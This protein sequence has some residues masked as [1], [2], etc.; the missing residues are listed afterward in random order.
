VFH[1]ADVVLKLRPVVAKL[2]EKWVLQIPGTPDPSEAW[3]NS[4]NYQ[5]GLFKEG[6]SIKVVVWV[7]SDM[8]ETEID[9][10]KDLAALGEWII[11]Q[12]EAQ[13][14]AAMRITEEEKRLAQ[15]PAPSLETALA[16]L[17]GGTRMQLGWGRWYETYFMT[18]G[19]LYRE[20][21]DEGHYDEVEATPEELVESMNNNREQARKQ[22]EKH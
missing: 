8:Q 2:D 10:L 11:P 22:C 12:L 21:F 16:A 6:S 14:V 15:I 9:S 3:F 4:D 19:K 1:F 7:G 20:I 17:R 18:D 5:I 13:R